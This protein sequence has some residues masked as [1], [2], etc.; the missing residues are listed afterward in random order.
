MDQGRET[1]AGQ[2]LQMRVGD[3][4][5]SAIWRGIPD[6]FATT[7]VAHG[8]GSDMK[9][10]FFEGIVD[11]LA[12][13]RVSTLRFNFPYAEEGRR[14][15]DRAAVLM[16]A[17]R[18]ALVAARELSAGRPVI[19]SGKSL[20]GRM[21]SMVAAD[22]GEDF[23][24]R[25]LIFFGYPLHAPGKR[26]QL[27]DAHLPSVRVPMLFIQGD[28]DSLAR[29][30]LVQGVVD[31]LKPLARLHR[32]ERGDHSFRV[33]GARRSDVDIG[34]DVAGV[35]AAFIQEIASP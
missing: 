13:A 3:R 21:A 24:A 33:R 31:R 1:G 25:A 23:T 16:G 7:V 19:A 5:V 9:H 29:F 18:A 12:A 10:P 28:A 6:A 8:A 34:R 30:D 17:W 27:R 32:V 14:A 22:A 15:P 4:S 20:G 35:A 2:Q 11:G 26:D